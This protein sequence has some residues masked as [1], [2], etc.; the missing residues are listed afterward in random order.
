M[1]N[2]MMNLR[3][4]FWKRALTPT[5]CAKLVGFTARRLME[6]EVEGLQ[7]LPRRDLGDA[8]RHSGPAHP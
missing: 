6:L 1:T 3:A 7:R 5:Y 2:E 4:R 8:R